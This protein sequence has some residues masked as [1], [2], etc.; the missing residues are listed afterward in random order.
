VFA[1]KN[2]AKRGHPLRGLTFGPLEGGLPVHPNVGVIIFVRD[3]RSVFPVGDSRQ[4]E[5]T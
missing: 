3:N 2:P 4:V 1:K 5:F